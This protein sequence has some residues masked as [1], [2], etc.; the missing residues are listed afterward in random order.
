MEFTTIFGHETNY[1]ITI[2]D[3]ITLCLK[4][5]LVKMSLSNAVTT[6]VKRTN[7]S[8]RQKCMTH[9]FLPHFDRF[10]EFVRLTLVLTWIRNKFIPTKSKWIVLWICLQRNH[11]QIVSTS[12]Q[13]IALTGLTLVNAKQI[14]VSCWRPVQKVVVLVLSPLPNHPHQ[15]YQNHLC[16]VIASTTIRTAHFGNQKMS[17][18]CRKIGWTKIVP[19]A[20]DYA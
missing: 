1:A 14:L 18:S 16:L 6:R 11:H 8:G 15:G 20:A 7:I 5:F 4:L 3:F 13:L 10:G 17:V 2:Q 12:I 9:N 19:E